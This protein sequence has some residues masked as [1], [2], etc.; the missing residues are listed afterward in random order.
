MSQDLVVYTLFPNEKEARFSLGDQDSPIR[1]LGEKLL[2]NSRSKNVVL[3]LGE[4]GLMTFKKSGLKP[5]DFYSIDSFAENIVDSV[6]SGDALLATTS[7]VYYI[8]KNIV[9][10]SLIG[11]MSAAIECAKKGNMPTTKIE[12]LNFVEKINKTLSKI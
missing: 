10:S 1:P 5:R 9:V 2:K 6:G 3:K 8:T 12:L 11:S 7:L 4:K